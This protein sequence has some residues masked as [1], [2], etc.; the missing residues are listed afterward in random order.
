MANELMNS[1]TGEWIWEIITIA[2]RI[3]FEYSVFISNS[4][5]NNICDTSSYDIFF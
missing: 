3:I 2:V 1:V 5:A 4:L